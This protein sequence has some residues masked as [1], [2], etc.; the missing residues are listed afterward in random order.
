MALVFICLHLGNLLVSES[1]QFHDS[2]YSFNPF[3]E[4]HHTFSFQY[5][6]PYGHTMF[7]SAIVT[8]C[9][10]PHLESRLLSQ[11][12]FGYVT[13][14]FF[15]P[16][17]VQGKSTSAMSFTIILVSF[18]TQVIH[19]H[20]SLSYICFMSL[21]GDT[22]RPSFNESTLINFGTSPGN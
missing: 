6:I 18:Y 3:E 20:S 16:P 14:S 1:Y 17:L 11:C 2:L 13:K 19:H 15:V 5:K 12:F 8:L 10:D 7:W 22:S 9:L 4:C 21:M